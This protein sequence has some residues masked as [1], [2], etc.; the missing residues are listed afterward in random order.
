MRPE[1]NPAENTPSQS[2]GAASLPLTRATLAER[3]FGGFVPFADL[4][5]SAV[6]AGKGVYL[7]LR[8]SALPPVFLVRSSAGHRKGH[9]PTTS[10]ATL[11]S[12]WAPGA[13]VVYVGKAAGHQGLRRRLNAYRRQ[14]HGHNAGHSG[15]EYIWQLADSDTLLVAWHTVA[16]PPAGQA[17]VEL[18]AEFAGLHGALPFTN[19]NRGSLI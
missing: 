19:H 4:P 8:P 9:D 15:G 7:V 13:T 18:I 10:T 11:N 14:G 5:H 6:P 1:P 3:G 16:D 17:E 12:A 2:Q